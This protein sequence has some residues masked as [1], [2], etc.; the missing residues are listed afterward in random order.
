MMRIN[1]NQIGN[2]CECCVDV[3]LSLFVRSFEKSEMH[4]SP[5]SMTGL[6][7]NTSPMTPSNKDRIKFQNQNKHSQ[8]HLLRQVRGKVPM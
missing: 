1:I 8:V 5:F 3:I 2:H 7:F 4:S 6:P